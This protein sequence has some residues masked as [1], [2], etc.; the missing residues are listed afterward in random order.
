MRGGRAGVR[1]RAVVTALV[2]A[3]V[4]ALP[5]P[6]A[7]AAPAGVWLQRTD[8]LSTD[9]IRLQVAAVDADGFA[10]PFTGRVTVSVGR[11]STTV[12]VNGAT[13]Q[14]EIEVPT[15]A[16]A[17][18]SATATAVLRAGGRTLRAAVVGIADVPPTV[19]LRGFGC[20]VV[21][22]KRT[23][24]AWQ[25]VRL[26]G[27]P[28]SYPAWTP[29]SDTFPAY[30]RS[31]RPSVITDSLDQPLRT[32]GAVVI[33]RGAKRVATIALPSAQRRLLFS[34]PWRGT[35]AGRFAP[36]AY[37]ATVTLVDAL[38]RTS[39]ATQQLLVARSD[40]GRCA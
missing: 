30:V 1:Q 9:P 27:R 5:A 2:L 23:R 11:T 25:V 16:L 4:A 13:G 29:A 7:E 18:G 3:A 35:V 36:G 31:V 34:A 8:P 40:A 12:P 28:I 22:P 19:E 21:T 26:N 33:R 32:R 37:T 6:V 20:G 39:T 17:G 14:E 10:T 24:V 15:T 38:G